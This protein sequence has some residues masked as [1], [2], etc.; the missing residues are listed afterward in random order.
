MSQQRAPARWSTTFG[1]VVGDFGVSRLA[2]AM[3]E[4]L[5]YAITNTSVYDWVAGRRFPRPIHVEAIVQVTG[6]RITADDIYRHHREVGSSA[7]DGATPEPSLQTR[8]HQ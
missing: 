6:G 4:R 8:E 3:S 5:S 2:Q 7:G 1:R